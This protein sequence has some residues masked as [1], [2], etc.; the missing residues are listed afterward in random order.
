MEADEKTWGPPITDEELAALAPKKPEG[1][2]EE[3]SKRWDDLE[4]DHKLLIEEGIFAKGFRVYGRQEEYIKEMR[5]S[6]PGSDLNA[7][8]LYSFCVK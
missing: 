6:F 4:H 3:Q 7:R 2:S 8:S 1:L 5:E